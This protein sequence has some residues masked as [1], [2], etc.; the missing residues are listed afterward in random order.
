MYKNV[1]LKLKINPHK[2]NI[3]KKSFNMMNKTN[4]SNNKSNFQKV[5]G[6]P[7]LIIC[8][9]SGSGK[10]KTIILKF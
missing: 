3:I 9:P 7:P 2:N 1:F 5:M 10:V 4:L 6:Y 8:G